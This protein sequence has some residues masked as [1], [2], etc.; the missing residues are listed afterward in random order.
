MI[1]INT[2]VHII[3]RNVLTCVT[4]C[5]GRYEIKEK[6]KTLSGQKKTFTGQK[7]KE[8][9]KFVPCNYVAKI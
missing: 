5:N 1:K 6:E 3:F 7:K 4:H 2:A 8:F 9:H